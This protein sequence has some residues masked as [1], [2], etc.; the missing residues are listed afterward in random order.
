MDTGFLAKGNLD[1]YVIIVSGLLEGIARVSEI[2]VLAKAPEDIMGYYR[3]AI[4]L[5]LQGIR[6]G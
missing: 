2:T 3:D 1:N 6:T 4:R 5:L